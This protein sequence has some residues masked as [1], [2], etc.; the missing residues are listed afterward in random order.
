[1]GLK[2]TLLKN[3]DPEVLK[4]SLERLSVS[5]STTLNPNHRH[6]ETHEKEE[7]ARRTAICDS[8]RFRSFANVRENNAVKWSVN[9]HTQ[10]SQPHP[11]L[12]VRREVGLSLLGRS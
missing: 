7:D 6:D 12:A 5:I 10:V 2:E 4:A 11:A 8:H 1:M 3:R 9:A